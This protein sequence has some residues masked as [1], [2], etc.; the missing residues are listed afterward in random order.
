M[1]NE[2]LAHAIAAKPGPRVTRESILARIST[3]EFHV[4]AGSTVTLCNITL[5]NG[6]SVRGESAC[7]DPANFDKAIGEKIAHDN[8]FAN[9]WSLFGFLLAEKIYS[10]RQVAAAFGEQQAQQQAMDKI[11]TPKPAE[12]AA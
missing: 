10:E 1:S 5:D 3:V 7:V 12:G 6:F 4:L 9:L 8:A 11:P 2:A